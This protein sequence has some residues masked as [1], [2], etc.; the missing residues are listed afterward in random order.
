MH[1]KNT[2]KISALFLAIFILFAGFLFF[3]VT[4]NVKAV[5][6]NEALKTENPTPSTVSA[7]KSPENAISTIALDPTKTVAEVSHGG[8]KPPDK[9]RNTISCLN[10]LNLPK[11][12]LL[13]I[14]EM[15]GWLLS[16]AAMMFGWVVDADKLSAVISNPA[17]YTVW[18]EVR[19]F[20][21]IFFILA[22]LYSAFSI[23]FQVGGKFGEKKIILTIVLMALLVNFSFPITRFVIDASNSLMYTLLLQ[24]FPANA[25]NP[26][27][28]LTSISESTGI[29][30]ILN[31]IGDPSFSQLFASIIFVFILALTFLA[32]AVLFL[33]R[34]VALAIL[35]IASPV[36]FVESIMGKDSIGFWDKLFKYAFFGP[37]MVFV[38]HIAISTMK[39]MGEASKLATGA[40]GDNVITAMAQFSIPL[41]ILWMG[42]GIAQKMGIEGASAVVGK[43]QNFA[44]GTG[45]SIW[46]ATSIP[47]GFKK[48]MDHYNKKGAPG[49]LGKIPGLRGS[50][51]TEATEDRIKG[52]L[53]KG[54]KGWKDAKKD[55]A[56]KSFDE[57]TKKASE[58]LESETTNTLTAHLDDPANI[59]R[60]RTDKS[61]A[62][63]YAGHAKQLLSD[64]AK[65]DEWKNTL[66]NNTDLITVANR[67]VDREVNDPATQTSLRIAAENTARSANLISGTSEWSYSV[68]NAHAQAETAKR[69]ELYQRTMEN[70]VTQEIKNVRDNVKSLRNTHTD[71]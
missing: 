9:S 19:D 20:I 69:T 28:I 57:D 52:F 29:K 40:Q 24:F 38:L 47:G 16:A 41:V 11:C 39:A 61:A 60:A 27:A 51:K 31:P 30:D 50:E 70:I 35:I 44:K 23:I 67:T 1:K 65:M 17:I 8:V 64:P 5:G 55:T 66:Q 32:M 25:D 42:M 45:T 56:K 10:P 14:L 53:I 7:I 58:G 68:A 48:T 63:K 3:D 62:V 12:I 4:L 15:V 34:V 18:T 43:A 21:N 6:F 37:I 33:I 46:K 71:I 22:L 26:Q 2:P 59:N 49:F 54:P 36:A 13:G